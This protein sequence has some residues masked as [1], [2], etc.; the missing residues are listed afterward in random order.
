MFWL[1][2][3][4][5]MA[6][7]WARSVRRQGVGGED[8]L[9]V[10]S[11]VVPAAILGARLFHVLSSPEHYLLR[12]ADALS[13]RGGLALW[14]AI[15]GGGL[16]GALAARARGLPVSVLLDAAAPGLAL[17]EAIGRIGCLIDGSNLGP[18]TTLPWGVQYAHPLAQAPDFLLAHHP[19]PLYHALAALVLFGLLLMLR[20][21]G[22]RVG[23]LFATWLALHALIRLGLGFVRV[24]PVISLGLQASQWWAVVALIGLGSGIIRARN[25]TAR[26]AAGPT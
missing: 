22:I 6:G 9:F 21:R 1:L 11:W 12:P 13:T 25:R 8:A 3:G 4:L 23:T 20:R 19:T 7:W 14:G 5:V 10:L 15:A 26:R 2:G 16:A 18:P 17:G 24:E